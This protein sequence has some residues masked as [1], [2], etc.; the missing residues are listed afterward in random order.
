MVICVCPSVSLMVTT[1]RQIFGTCVK[2]NLSKLCFCMQII[3]RLY[4]FSSCDGN[5]MLCDLCFVTGSFFIPYLVCLLAGGVPIFFLEIALGQLMSQGGLAAW[6]IC[7]IFKG[8][9]VKK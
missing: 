5:L 2:K 7:P 6:N 8:R 4:V 1:S 3:L 9:M